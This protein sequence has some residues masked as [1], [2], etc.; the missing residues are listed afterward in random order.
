MKDISKSIFDD[1]HQDDN[2]SDYIVNVIND[3]TLRNQIQ[4]EILAKNLKQKQKDVRLRIESELV[5]TIIEENIK[6][7]RVKRTVIRTKLM[8]RINNVQTETVQDLTKTK[9]QLK[10][11]RQQPNLVVNGSTDSI[12]SMDS[13]LNDSR[14]DLKKFK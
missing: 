6:L 10:E 4:I 3:K 5:T 8:P 12:D 2:K 9:K 11:K 14:P 7:N 1:D 13:G